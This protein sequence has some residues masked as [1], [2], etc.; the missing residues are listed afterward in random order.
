M[1]DAPER[2]WANPGMPGYV[3]DGPM[4]DV[5]DIEY[6]RTDH[7]QA[8]VAAAYK[9]AADVVGDHEG[10]TFGIDALTPDDARSAL[11]RIVQERVNEALERAAKAMAD[12]LTSDT[13]GQDPEDEVVKDRIEY[14][15]SLP[16]AIRAIKGEAP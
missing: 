9:H 15:E 2:I 12:I 6:T 3:D 4:P 11:D 13:K 8:L 10:V 1:T 16:A 5:Y 7:S 14:L